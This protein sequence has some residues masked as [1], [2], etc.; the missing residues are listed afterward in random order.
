MKCL[1][2][3]S[4]IESR[5]GRVCDQLDYL[6]RPMSIGKDSRCGAAC[7]PNEISAVR[8]MPETSKRIS[9]R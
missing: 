9:T 1:A 5:R 3:L 6:F 8:A 7:Q 4:R 2:L